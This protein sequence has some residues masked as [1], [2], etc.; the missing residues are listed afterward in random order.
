[1]ADKS[2]IRAFSL[3]EIVVATLICSV[4]AAGL[5][6]AL[7]TGFR[8][9]KRIQDPGKYQMDVVVAIEQFARQLRQAM[10]IPEEGLSGKQG[11]IAFVSP[12]N[13]IPTRYVYEYATVREVVTLRRVPTGGDLND[14]QE[15]EILKN[16]TSFSLRYLTVPLSGQPGSWRDDW[17]REDGLPLA[18]MVEGVS[19]GQPFKKTVMIPVMCK[20]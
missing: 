16:V 13:D 5:G 9:W 20:K 12:A 8:L 3:I 18:V 19:A 6:A 4:V 2:R 10:D 1:M 14:A 11:S 15:E 7:M 17:S